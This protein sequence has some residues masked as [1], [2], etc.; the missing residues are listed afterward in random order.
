M[1]PATLRSFAS[2]PAAPLPGA[3]G[4]LS[5]RVAIPQLLAI[6]GTG[7]SSPTTRQIISLLGDLSGSMTAT[8]SALTGSAT[9]AI[10]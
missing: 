2:A 10:R 6:T 8:T 4:A 3:S 9:L 1:H 5:F 7:A